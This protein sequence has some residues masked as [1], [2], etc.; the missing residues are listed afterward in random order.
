MKKKEGAQGSEA[1]KEG[2]KRVLMLLT[3]PFR[4]DPRVYMEAKTLL[5]AGYSVTVLAWDRE[6]S[7]PTTEDF[8]G[9]KVVRVRVRA[10]YGESGS[11]VR[12]LIGFY[13]SA[14]RLAGNMDFDIIH[15]NDFDT[16]PLSFLIRRRNRKAKIVYD[17]HDHYSSMISDVI[18]RSLARAVGRL[19]RFL[20]SRADGR[21][22]ASRPL[23]DIVFRDMPF[24]TVMNCKKREEYDSIPESAVKEL[25]KKIDPKNRFLIVY[26]GI[27]KLWAP[28]PH[29][30]EAVKRV[31]GAFLA[32]GGK[33]PHE[34]EIIRRIK[35]NENMRYLGWVKKDDVPLYTKASDLIIL[36]PSGKKEYTKVGVATKIMEGMAAGKPIISS[37]GTE[38]GRAVK[39]CGCGFLCGFGDVECISRRIKELMN[40]RE[41]YARFSENSR[42]CFEERYNWDIM[43]SRLLRLYDSLR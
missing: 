22:A 40:N 18:P 34:K 14:I 31:P 9:I 37:P 5:E 15:A 24:E 12:G 30:I 10:G 27:L 20:A 3:N 19:E 21:I 2:R 4:P 39:E 33:G 41:I 23:G 25:R 32:V 43:A 42:K 26:I 28:I 11:F 6:T 1:K 8:E 7:Y 17:A 13:R 16:L 36:T 35:E 38:S 29:V